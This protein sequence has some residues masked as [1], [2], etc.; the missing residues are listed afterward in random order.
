[1]GLKMLVKKFFLW[2]LKRRGLEVGK[3]LKIYNT[4]IDYSHCFLIRIGDD[5][6]ISNSTILAHDATTKL[7]LGKTKI[8]R[9][10]IG[11]RVFIGYGSI[12]LPNV[13]IG[14][15]VIVAAGSVVSKNIPDDCVVAGTPAKIIG[16]TSDY[17]NKNKVLMDSSPVYDTYWKNKTKDQIERI[18]K[19]L[20]VG[21][22]FDE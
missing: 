8:G 1:M 20:K 19:D 12:I 5:V 22:A 6:T 2:R 9:V 4:K 10:I 11:D 15:D 16:K 17:I 14:N 18:C 13:Q 7:V 3:N 21:F